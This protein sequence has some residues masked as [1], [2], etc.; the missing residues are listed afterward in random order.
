MYV[1]VVTEM[2]QILYATYNLEYK[3][4]ERLRYLVI[5]IKCTANN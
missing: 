4:V 3:I 2:C 1:P 5:I